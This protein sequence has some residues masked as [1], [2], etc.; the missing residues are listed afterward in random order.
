MHQFNAVFSL[1]SVD[2]DNLFLRIRWN[3]HINDKI[4]TIQT[5]STNNRQG[6]K[7]INFECHFCH[8]AVITFKTLR[9]H[10]YNPILRNLSITD[11]SVITLLKEVFAF[12]IQNDINWFQLS[13]QSKIGFQLPYVESFIIKETR[14]NMNQKK[15]KIKQ[16]NI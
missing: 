2:I 16:Q 13:F 10:K 5:Q 1:F 15:V 11:R 4:W 7:S 12:Y 9:K 6:N 3:N 14:E 8:R